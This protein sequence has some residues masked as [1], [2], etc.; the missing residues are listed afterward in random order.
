M[1]LHKDPSSG[2]P[3][4]RVIEIEHE[5]GQTTEGM[6]WLALGEEPVVKTIILVEISIAKCT[7]QCWAREKIAQVRGRVWM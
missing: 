1:E 3:L 6:R 7:V 2:T 5:H 4:C